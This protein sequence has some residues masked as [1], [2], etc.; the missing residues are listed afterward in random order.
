MSNSRISI[1]RLG[2][3][4]AAL[5]LSIATQINADVFTFQLKN[6]PADK[7]VPIIQPHLSNNVSLTSNGYQLIVSGTQS[8]NNIVEQLLA[9]LDIP[10]NEYMVELKITNIEPTQVTK[11]QSPPGNIG[12]RIK[13]YN[14]QPNKADLKHFKIRLIENYPAYIST[15]ESFPEPRLVSHYNSFIPK[16]KR[17]KAVTGFYLSL[18]AS[19]PNEV[20]INAS[21]SQQQRLRNN[22]DTIQSS[23]ASSNLS[24]KLEQW[25]LFASTES[26]EV[27]QNTK[28]YRSSPNEQNRYYLIKVTPIIRD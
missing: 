9:D 7:L 16:T 17:T 10:F 26:L 18:S 8:D 28:T 22:S 27:K 13:R 20:I 6:Q 21:A 2:T 14:S 1:K 5:L 11:K 25:T 3:I 23:A 12:K 4:W 19:T 24:A 15:D